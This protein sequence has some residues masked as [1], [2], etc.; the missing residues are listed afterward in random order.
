MSRSRPLIP[1]YGLFFRWVL[2]WVDAERAHRL[3]EGLMRGFARL[4][5]ALRAVDFLLRP[6]DPGLRIRAMGVE[7]R[8]PLCV[9]AGMDKDGRWHQSL[10]ALGFGAIEV[11][12]VT[13]RP[14]PGN[15]PPRMMRILSRRALFNRLGFPSEGA[16]AVAG[17]LLDRRTGATIGVNVGKSREVEL[18]DAVADY[19]ESVR[20]LAP[21]A[22]YIVLN[23]SSPNTPNLTAMQTV[24]RLDALLDGV[25]EELDAV[26]GTRRPPLLLKLGPDLADDEIERIAALAV[27]RRLDGIVAVNTTVSGEGL[28][29]TEAL[30]RSFERGGGVSG[31]PLRA[32]SL[33]V[34]RLLRRC[35]GDRVVLVSA[36]GVESAEDAWQR[37]LAGAVLVQAHTALVYG[38]PLWPRRLNRGLARRL[39]E[40]PWSSLEEAVGQ[41]SDAGAPIAS[42]AAPHRRPI[43]A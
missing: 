33:E 15:P 16:E 12:T 19:R 43:P 13:A 37:I 31:P 3:V 17:R 10:A 25:E 40:S 22:D 20:R 35:V 34:L 24:E 32:R 26:A 5:G 21:H 1:F 11:G 28:E 6:R 30:E 29:T 4:P 27:R 14:Q 41:G 8:G 18:D 36:G 7:F 23:V 42:C 2:R 39:R 9:A 38:G